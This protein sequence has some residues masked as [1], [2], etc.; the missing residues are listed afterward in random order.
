MITWTNAYLN[1]LDEVCFSKGYNSKEAALKG[2]TKNKQVTYL[3]KPIKIV[4]K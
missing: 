2:R 3:G 4:L 1:Y